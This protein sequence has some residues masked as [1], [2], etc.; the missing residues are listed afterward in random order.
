M[1]RMFY[2]G[3]VGIVTLVCFCCTNFSYGYS[4]GDASVRK[5][6]SIDGF[7]SASDFTSDLIG[8]LKSNTDLNSNFNPDYDPKLKSNSDLNLCPSN[9]AV[10]SIWDDLMGEQKKEEGRIMVALETG[11]AQLAKEKDQ[12]NAEELKTILGELEGLESIFNDTHLFFSEITTL[13]NGKMVIKGRALVSTAMGLQKTE[14]LNTYY[15]VFS[16]KRDAHQGFPIHE[17]YTKKEWERLKKIKDFENI[18]P[19]R[20]KFKSKDAEAIRRYIQNNEKIID[21]FIK[22]I[23]YNGQFTYVGN[24]KYNIGKPRNKYLETKYYQKINTEMNK[25]LRL[26][27]ENFSGAIDDKNV[28]LLRIP[29]GKPYPVIYEKSTETGELVPVIVKAHTSAYGLYV[30]L[31]EDVFDVLVGM[32]KETLDSKTWDEIFKAFMHEIGEIYEQPY[33]VTQDGIINALDTAYQKYIDCERNAQKVKEQ[34]P[35]LDF[36]KKL[37][38]NEDLDRRE[39]AMSDSAAKKEESFEDQ[40][41]KV[42]AEIIGDHLYVKWTCAEMPEG[43]MGLTSVKDEDLSGFWIVL[44]EYFEQA[45]YGF[46]VTGE[47]L[48]VETLKTPDFKKF[49]VPD[50]EEAIDTR[51]KSVVVD[52]LRHAKDS[53]KSKLNQWIN[54]QENQWLVNPGKSESEKDRHKENALMVKFLR[55]NPNMASIFSEDLMKLIFGNKTFL[56]KEPFLSQVSE[57]VVSLRM[58]KGHNSNMMDFAKIIAPYFIKKKLSL[59][60][61]K[62]A[63]I[64]TRTKVLKEIAFILDQYLAKILFLKFDKPGKKEF[65]FEEMGEVV[66]AGISRDLMQNMDVDLSEEF[67]KDLFQYAVSMTKDAVLVLSQESKLKLDD[68]VQELVNNA[69]GVSD[70]SFVFTEEFKFTRNFIREKKETSFMEILEGAIAWLESEKRNSYHNAVEKDLKGFIKEN[71]AGEITE[72]GVESVLTGKS[73]GEEKQYDDIVEIVN[74]ARQKISYYH[75]IYNGLLG[76]G[77]LVKLSNCLSLDSTQWIKKKCQKV[78]DFYDLTDATNLNKYLEDGNSEGAEKKGVLR[79]MIWYKILPSHI[80]TWI[81]EKYE[82]ISGKSGETMFSG[83]ETISLQLMFQ[84]RSLFEIARNMKVYT[85]LNNV[86]V[87]PRTHE[88]V[89][90]RRGINRGDYGLWLGELFLRKFSKK[91]DVLGIEK[92]MLLMVDEAQHVGKEDVTHSEITSIQNISQKIDHF[93]SF[94]NGHFLQKDVENAWLDSIKVPWES[95]LPN[96]TV[97][98][99]EK[100]VKLYDELEN[101]AKNPDKKNIL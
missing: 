95:N 53:T 23:I 83:G 22:D 16:G 57:S 84:I 81:S 17:I 52:I 49:K 15:A 9:L 28:T 78:S 61:R 7:N 60:A 5:V 77:K 66:L 45:I 48:G 41:T 89:H 91:E 37:N 11:L 33:I 74:E 40:V 13:T 21:P 54:A 18:L 101:F 29:K 59:I 44:K 75:N 32:K 88:F 42:L 2:K 92:L 3:F 19:L 30:F 80:Q 69:F 90:V 51:L 82:K 8:G 31:D 98:R 38:F 34:M 20:E 56:M 94:E 65:L 14:D 35:K 70:I 72:K 73:M 46:L 86:F 79:R 58:G 26:F 39:Y 100:I 25:F 99:C 93:M 97:G 43:K 96:K 10:S 55:E 63:D 4:T 67:R 50:I 76:E 62:Q 27:D 68:T 47:V 87:S 85:V 24:P 36:S 64:D 6:N 71:Q 1:K 12:I